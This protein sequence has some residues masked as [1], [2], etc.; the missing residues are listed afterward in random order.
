MKK[1]INSKPQKTNKQVF[2][3]CFNIMSALLEVIAVVLLFTVVMKRRPEDPASAATWTTFKYFTT[4]SN[5][6]LLIASIISAIYIGLYWAGK[7]KKIPQWEYIVKLIAVVSTTLTMFVTL[8]M[9]LPGAIATKAF[10][11][12]ALYLGSNLFMHLICPLVGIVGFL[13]FENRNDV[14]LVKTLYCLI[15]L[16]IYCIFY[17]AM[18]YTHQ[19]PDG[20][21]MKGYDWYKFCSIGR[22]YA[23]P[24]ILIGMIGFYYLFT[25]LLWL[26]NR[27]IN[28][29]SINK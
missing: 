18:A 15:P 3:F 23:T 26:G 4:D 16:I 6:V 13:L 21:F 19:N 11:P 29:K 17:L 22:P 25:W 27:R 7:V 10:I 12:A 14:K 24:F 1:Q 2:A 8:F 28:I 5:I 20:T 9:L